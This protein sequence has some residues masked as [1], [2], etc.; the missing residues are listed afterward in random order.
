[1]SGGSYEYAFGRVND[2]ANNLHNQREDP[3]RR[4]FANHLRLVATAM[5]ACEWVDSGDRGPGD[6]HAAIRAV[7]APGA[8]LAAAVQIAEEALTALQNAIAAAKGG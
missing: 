5:H 4:A 8:E 2:M 7:L 1:M 6:E 3:L